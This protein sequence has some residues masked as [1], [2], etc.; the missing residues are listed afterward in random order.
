MPKMLELGWH[1]PDAGGNGLGQNK[2]D[3]TNMGLAAVQPNA[4][5]ISLLQ[6]QIWRTQ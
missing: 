1:Q 3:V 2:I 5:N 6:P 4:A